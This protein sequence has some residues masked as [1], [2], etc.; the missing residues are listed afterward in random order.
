M[1]NP[2]LENP[3]PTSLRSTVLCTGGRILHFFA[4]FALFSAQVAEFCTYCI[5][6]T[7]LCT[8]GRILH[9]LHFLHCPLRRR[10]NFAFFA[11]FLHR[12]QN[13]AFLHLFCTG[14]R[15]LHF[16]ALFLHCPLHR[17][18]NFAFFLLILYWWQ[19]FTFFAP[20]SAQIAIFSSLQNFA[21]YF[22]GVA[23]G[24]AAHWDF[25]WQVLHT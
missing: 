7:V 9:F 8:G 10:Q 15:I 14:G 3:I 4:F 24:G 1:P 21:F 23:R 25:L 12:W 22:S 11:L 16:F 17:R 19:N 6:C 5:F 18:Q 2:D 13:F 20:S